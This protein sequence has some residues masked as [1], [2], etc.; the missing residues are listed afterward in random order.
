MKTVENMQ[1][2]MGQKYTVKLIVLFF[3]IPVVQ[4]TKHLT[5]MPKNNFE[6]CELKTMCGLHCKD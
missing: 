1:G 4:F 5:K 2:G 6:T 3:N